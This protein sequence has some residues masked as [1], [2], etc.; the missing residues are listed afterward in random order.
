[1]SKVNLYH[2][3]CVEVMREMEEG[4]V[5][6]VITSPPYN[7]GLDYDGEY[8][9]NLS[10]CDYV[11]FSYEWI[12][13]MSRLMSDGGMGYIVVI[14]KILFDLKPIIEQNNLVYL[15][16]LVWCKPNMANGRKFIIGFRS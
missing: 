13:Q 8:D 16:L 12:S 5:D 10:Q 6:I 4:C 1:M 9:D 14:D 2:G 7:V 11:E 15:D 3:D